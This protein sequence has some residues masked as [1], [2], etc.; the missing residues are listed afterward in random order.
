[1]NLLV[2][3]LQKE[4]IDKNLSYVRLCTIIMLK[5]ILRPRYHPYSALLAILFVIAKH[6]LCDHIPD[7][8]HTYNTSCVQS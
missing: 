6:E 3:H 5:V 1:M 2:C 8:E 4:E 7:C